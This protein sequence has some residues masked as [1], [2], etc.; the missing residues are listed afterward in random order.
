MPRPVKTDM[1]Q[2]FRFRARA[3]DANNAPRLQFNAGTALGVAQAEPDAGFSSCGTP[4]VSV[5][6]AEYREGTYVYTRKYPGIPT[7]DDITVQGG[8]TR[9]N[10][11]FWLWEKQVVEGQGEYRCTVEI[12]HFARD[13]SYVGGITTA[14]VVAGTGSTRQ[15]VLQNLTS[16][17]SDSP[18]GRIYILYEAWPNNHK[19]ASDFEAT[20]SDVS[21]QDLTI[22]YENFDI[23]EDVTT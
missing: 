11:T 13:L 9:G 14:Q 21:V 20:S 17:K 12:A 5:E 7:V 22:V 18:P 10:T 4:S 19:V 3:F 6:V 15:N 23:L 1:M 2:A 8:V 16:I